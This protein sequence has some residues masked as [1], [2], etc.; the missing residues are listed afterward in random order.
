[1]LVERSLEQLEAENDDRIVLDY[2]LKYYGSRQGAFWMLLWDMPKD[3]QE[4]F[5]QVHS[6]R[7][8]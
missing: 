3:I 6:R 5:R 1:M 4:K 8:G 2:L 7:V